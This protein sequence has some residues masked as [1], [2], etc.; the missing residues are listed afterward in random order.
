MHPVL[1]EIFGVPISPYG[2]LIAAGLIIG[3]TLARRRAHAVGIPEDAVLDVTFWGVIAGF[4]GARV[5]YILVSW[6]EFTRDPLALIL[7]RQGFVFLGGLITAVLVVVFLMRRWRVRFWPMA[8]VL[9]APLALGH[10][11]GRAGCFFAGC[12]HGKPTTLP[13]GVR[14]PRFIQWRGEPLDLD[15]MRI[16]DGHVLDGLGADVGFVS[17]SPA[18]YD[19]AQAGL[20]AW[21]DT[22]CAPVHPTQLYDVA[23]QLALFA[24]LT[25]LW[26]RRLFQGQIALVYLWI[27][28]LTRIVLELFR[29]DLERGVWFGGVSTSQILS[30][31]MIFV[32]LALTLLRHRLFPAPDASPLTSGSTADAGDQA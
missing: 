2:L 25:L 13:W 16:V 5:T 19:Q 26:R 17:G 15:Q 28:P 6:E 14:F 27:Y 24:L 11:L 7:S 12:C 20:C 29:G 9:A 18:F 30:G 32:A 8:D 10:A 1:V 23:I 22:Q 3:I 21:G 31:L 4:V